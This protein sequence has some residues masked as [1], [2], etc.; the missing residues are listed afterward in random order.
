MDYV[1][2]AEDYGHERPTKSYPKRKL[3]PQFDD[4]A[5]EPI[6]SKYNYVNQPDG[7][8]VDGTKRLIT[9]NI[10]P[11][12]LAIEARRQRFWATRTT[13]VRT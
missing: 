4:E 9:P 8:H 12:P 5:L 11:H 6:P 13:Y 10:S 2:A 7:H 1:L 3:L